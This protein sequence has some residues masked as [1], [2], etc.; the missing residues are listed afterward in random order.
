M[1]QTVFRADVG[2]RVPASAKLLR[3][4]KFD[5]SRSGGAQQNDRTRKSPGLGNRLTLWPCTRGAGVALGPAS[6]HNIFL[7]DPNAQQVKEQFNG[8]VPSEDVKR[9]LED[10]RGFFREDG[11]LRGIRHRFSGIRRLT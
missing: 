6:H 5:G 11:G 7:N 2:R 3:Q 9:V 4:T 10:D 8:N 1:Q